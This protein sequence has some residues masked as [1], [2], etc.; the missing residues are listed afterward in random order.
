MKRHLVFPFDFDSRAVGLDDDTSGWGEVEKRQFEERNAAL[1]QSLKDEYGAGNFVRT[2]ADFK[3]LGARPFSIVAHHNALYHSACEAFLHG[4]Y[5]PAL[6]AACALGERML[7]HLILDLR[8]DFKSTAEYSE[9]KDRGSFSNWN[10]ACSV[11]SAWRVFQTDRVEPEFRALARLRNRSLHFNA[12]APL[13]VREDALKAFGHLSK[14][15]ADQ[16]GFAGPQRWQIPDTAGAFFVKHEYESDPFIRKYYIPQC[17]YVSPLYAIKFIPEGIL[18]FDREYPEG[19]AIS[20]AEFVRLL[21]TRDVKEMAPSDL[22]PPFGVTIQA[23]F[24]GHPVVPVVAT[25]PA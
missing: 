10:R 18:F 21:N 7:N 15:I 2:L 3:A 16:F 11:L 14:I 8:D 6:T 12:A 17:P 23:R 22:P 25:K 5:F 4:Q 24:H 1:F 13:T 9:V 19:P 20:D